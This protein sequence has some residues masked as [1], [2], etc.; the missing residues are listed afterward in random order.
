M[1]PIITQTRDP[2]CGM[3]VS[4]NVGA[5][6][7]EHNSVRYLFCAEG[8][9]QQFI[10]KPDQ[11]IAVS[12]QPRRTTLARELVIAIV[13]FVAALIVVLVFLSMQST[14]KKSVLREQPIATVQSAAGTSEREKP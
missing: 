3:T 4:E 5:I 8:C 6:A 14:T 13:L 1:N 12:T 11:Y 2:V 7:W 10:K 9:K